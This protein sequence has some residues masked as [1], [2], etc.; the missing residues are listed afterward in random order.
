[1]LLLLLLLLPL[2]QELQGV[3]CE[4][5]LLFASAKAQAGLGNNFEKAGT[6]LLFLVLFQTRQHA[7]GSA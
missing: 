2:L 5:S 1:L 6:R 7:A 4:A 3:K